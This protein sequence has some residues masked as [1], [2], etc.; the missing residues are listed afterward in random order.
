MGGVAAVSEST[1]RRPNL[2]S[3]E[4]L[5]CDL[6]TIAPWRR[7]LSLMTPFALAILFFLLA[8]HE[9]W[10]GAVACTMALTFVTYGS[11]SHDLVHGTLRLTRTVNDV[12]LFAIELI[13][14]RSGHAY[15]IVHL[16]HHARF[17][18][19]D[20]LEGA[21]AAMTWWRALLDGVT[22]QPRLWFYAFRTRRD[23]HWIVGEAIAITVLIVV[24]IAIAPWTVAPASYAGLMIGGSWLFPFITSFIP[25][26]ANGENELMRTRLFRGR[27]LSIVAFEHLYHL[28]HHLYPQVPHH[29]WPRLA[30]RLDP[31]FARAGVR[32]VRLLF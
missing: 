29:H 24:S 10:I 16:H 8:T 13:S 18:A 27:V 5:G 6:L 9:H 26:D 4:H 2:P 21:A 25:H 28:E 7:A 14:F 3:I 11:I 15:R 30:R 23:R 17:P 22:L 1:R 20:D 31:Y 12:F 32:A 19:S